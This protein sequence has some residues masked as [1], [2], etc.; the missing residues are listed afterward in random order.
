MEIEGRYKEICDVDVSTFKTVVLR[1]SEKSWC[2]EMNL[3]KKI[4]PKR[5][6]NTIYIFKPE[7]P[8][9]YNNIDDIKALRVKIMRGWSIFAKDAKPIVKSVLKHYPKGGVIA[10][11]MLARLKPNGSI[12]EHK[13]SGPML[14]NLHRIHIPI[15]TNPN[16]R[17][18]V[19]GELVN[20]QAGKA[21]EINNTVKHSVYNDGKEHRVHLILDYIPPNRYPGASDFE[22]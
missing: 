11:L 14:R 7:N 2:A 9:E 21:Y 6:T 1:Q 10:Q 19:D 12:A 4:A 13:D 8:T 3:Q 5:D 22:R 20:M 17:F 18:S 16:V 15:I